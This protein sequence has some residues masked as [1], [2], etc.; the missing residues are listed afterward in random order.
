MFATAGFT[1]KGKRLTI[2]GTALIVLGLLA[3]AFPVMVVDAGVWMLLSAT[4]TLL[5]VA[6]VV[7]LRWG[8]TDE[9]RNR[10]L[11]AGGSPGRRLARLCGSQRS[12][13][14]S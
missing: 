6:A 11:A 7:F 4:G 2:P 5:V 13:D 9:D 1:P 3:V 12:V 10:L 8:L 14:E